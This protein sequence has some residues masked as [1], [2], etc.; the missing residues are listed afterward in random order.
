MGILQS[1]P[2][3]KVHEIYLQGFIS[4]YAV[5]ELPFLLKS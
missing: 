1:F 5:R 3:Q 2:K 4:T